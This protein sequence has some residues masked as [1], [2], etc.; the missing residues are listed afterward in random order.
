[1]PF[2]HLKPDQFT[3]DV[4]DRMQQAFDQVCVK[5][6]LGPDNPLRS[7]LATILIELATED[8]SENLL[9]RA[10][11]ALGHRADDEEQPA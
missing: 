4:L 10:L 5:L 2:R 6:N 11:S 9:T 8:E 7:K 3:P 1:M